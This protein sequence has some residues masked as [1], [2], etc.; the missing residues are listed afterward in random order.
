MIFTGTL[1]GIKIAGMAIISASLVLLISCIT[2][3]NNYTVVVKNAYFETLYSVRIDSVN[4][5]DTLHVDEIADA[6][7]IAKN[8]FLFSAETASGL[9]LQ[10]DL[11]IN[12]YEGKL[13]LVV[14]KQ[15]KLL[16]E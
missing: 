10:T 9:L 14:N 16:K 5:A 8:N 11:Y 15:G 4:L 6:M 13:Y 7:V 2:D 3:M 1:N 12:G